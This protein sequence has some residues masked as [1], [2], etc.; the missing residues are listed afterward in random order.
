MILKVLTGRT[1]K[2]VYRF[3][4]GSI[5]IGRDP[6]STIVVTGQEM[7]RSHAIVTREG[8]TWV[9]TDCGST[10]GT[11]VNGQSVDKR[12]LREGDRISL[13]DLTLEFSCGGPSARIPVVLGG[14][15]V[16]G[17]LL[18]VFLT[19]TTGRNSHIMIGGTETEDMDAPPSSGKSSRSGSTADRAESLL[20]T[21]Q[22][23]LRDWRISRGNAYRAQIA[24]DQALPLLA[25]DP[26]RARMA[27]EGGEEARRRVEE[28][29]RA[30]RFSAERA[31][32]AGDRRAAEAELSAILEAIPDNEDPRAGYA[33]Q[34]LRNLGSEIGGQ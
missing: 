17:V 6:S 7:S 16:L 20:K 25:G 4:D 8:K 30:H 13:G 18:A 9:L 12:T 23:R 5:S 27:R 3:S 19:G 28:E 21:G 32:R 11:C 14:F 31:I 33:H 10:N 26:R 15:A 34:R 1:G 22:E 29:F 24:F 2:T